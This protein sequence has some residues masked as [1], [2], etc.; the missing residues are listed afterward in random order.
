MGN[1]IRKFI[2]EDTE[3]LSRMIEH[4]IE[5]SYKW[6]YPMEVRG[7]FKNENSP[8]EIIE[9]AIK[10]NVLVAVDPEDADRL[11]GTGSLISN[12]IFAVYVHPEHQGNGIGIKLMEELENR[13]IANGIKKIELSASISSKD[14]YENLGY[15][16]GPRRCKADN[17][18]EYIVY[19]MKKEI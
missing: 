15:I 4:T 9:R 3:Q 10:E 19:D 7:L 6:V 14:F 13:A 12:K 8:E 5:E 11:I 2:R 16:G 18:K 17:D 1:Y